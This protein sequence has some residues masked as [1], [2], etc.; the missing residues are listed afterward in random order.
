M[1][2]RFELIDQ[3]AQPT[4]VVRRRAAVEQLPRVLGPAWGAVMACAG[5]VGA[6]PAEAPFAAFHNTDMQDLDVEIGFAFDRPLQGEGEVQASEIP[7]GR[8]VQCMHVGPF[9]QLGA[10][11]A[12]MHAWMAQQGLQHAGP[13]YE[14]YLDDPAD[15]PMER[16]RTRVVIP[17]R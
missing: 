12:A 3:A 16:V 7:A 17:V 14:H 4:L 8:A 6:A 15:T 1:S 5:K 13:S 11:Y 2:N 9:Q 10:T